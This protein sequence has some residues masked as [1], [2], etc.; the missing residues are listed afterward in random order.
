M[1]TLAL[2]FPT[3]WTGIVLAT[4]A[5][6][7]LHN[8]ACPGCLDASEIQGKI[9]YCILRFVLPIVAHSPEWHATVA[10][11][12]FNYS[13]ETLCEMP[14]IVICGYERRDV[15]PAKGFVERILLS[16]IASSWNDLEYDRILVDATACFQASAVRTWGSQILEYFDM[17]SLETYYLS[18]LICA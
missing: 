11:V 14:R 4:Q 13:S 3:E 16:S 7:T 2:W 15:E 6:A 5:T 8:L 12:D 17:L 9:C 1:T 10:P 18:L